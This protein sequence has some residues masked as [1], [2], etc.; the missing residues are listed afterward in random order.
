LTR[1]LG[2]QEIPDSFR[3]FMVE[4]ESGELKNSER[5]LPEDGMEEH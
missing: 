4:R 1:H 2:R 3:D 5:D